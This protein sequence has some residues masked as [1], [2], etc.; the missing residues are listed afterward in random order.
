MLKALFIKVIGKTGKL[1]DMGYISILMVQDTKE[2]GLMI[3]MK[4]KEEKH[5]Q[6]GH[7]SKVLTRMVR[8]MELESFPG[9]ISVLIQ[10]NFTITLCMVLVVINGLTGKST[11]VNGK[12][13]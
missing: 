11:M 6:M 4:E 3:K 5:G 12:I 8:N 2:S 9:Q 1:M 13:I 7:G 10:A